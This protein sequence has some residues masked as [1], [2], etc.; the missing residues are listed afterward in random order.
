M[1]GIT[2]IVTYTF[3]QKIIIGPSHLTSQGYTNGKEITFF[4]KVR[5]P[6]FFTV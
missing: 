3:Y 1:E 2:S 4:V 5:K 6:R